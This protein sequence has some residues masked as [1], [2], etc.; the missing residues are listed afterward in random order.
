MSTKKVLRNEY[1]PVAELEKVVAWLCSKGENTSSDGGT[2][3]RGARRSA[4]TVVMLLDG[5][6]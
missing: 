5:V 2:I 3:A 6:E 4:A 1:T